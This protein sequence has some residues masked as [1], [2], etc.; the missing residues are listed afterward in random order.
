[1]ELTFL[2]CRLKSCNPCFQ[3][4]V[5]ST[6]RQP[7]QQRAMLLKMLW[8]IMYTRMGAILSVQ[9]IHFYQTVSHGCFPVLSVQGC[10]CSREGHFWQ[11][12][13]ANFVCIRETALCFFVCLRSHGCDGLTS[14]W[15]GP[16]FYMGAN[17]LWGNQNRIPPLFSNHL[18]FIQS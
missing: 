3:T 16:M 2:F 6:G 4:F 7:Y 1:M 11:M 5:P 18:L 17:W 13:L 10:R 15:M 9:R 14:M 8:G 12:L